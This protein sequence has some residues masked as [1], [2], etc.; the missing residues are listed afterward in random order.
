MA[1]KVP[2]LSE[3]LT[4]STTRSTSHSVSWPA[5]SGRYSTTYCAQTPA[6]P[7]QYTGCR[8]LLGPKAP[9]TWPHSVKAA[10]EPP[11]TQVSLPTRT[12]TEGGK[13]VG[14]QVGK[15]GPGE[16]KSG[17]GTQAGLAAAVGPALVL[18]SQWQRPPKS[19]EL[20]GRSRQAEELW[21]HRRQLPGQEEGPGW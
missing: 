3:R 6:P 17:Q 14:E 7:A 8:G 11:S 16:E 19:S 9:C 4:S 1:L 12:Y 10:A 2:L 13:E 20:C 18:P 21:K 5:I 15:A